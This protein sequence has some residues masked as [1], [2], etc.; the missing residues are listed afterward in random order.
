MDIVFVSD[1]V[2]PYCLVAKEAL[3]QALALLD[4]DASITYQ[5]FELNPEP[6]P[7]VDTWSDPVRRETYKVLAQPCREL[8]LA[9]H[10]PPKIVPRPRTRL[11]FE[12]WFFARA[13]G[14]GD[15]YNDLV[16]RAYFLDE[17]DIGQI[18]V[19]TELAQEAGLD[20]AAFRQALETGVYTGA[21]HEA[22]AYARNVLK[23]TGVPTIYI[24]GEKVSL[25]S[26]TLG[27]MVGIL[28]GAASAGGPGISRGEDGC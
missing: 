15:A 28:N 27:E 5:P 8:G 12:G 10:L 9:M 2:C 13:H 18:D 19:L 6:R 14:R 20:P 22:V 11:A 4:L 24:N 17:R 21:E 26:Y 25:G 3:S 7:Q 16:Y 1:Y 23:P